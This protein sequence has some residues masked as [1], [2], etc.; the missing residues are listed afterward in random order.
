MNHL[1]AQ[2]VPYLALVVALVAAVIDTKTGRIPNYL[3]L[4]CLLIAPTVHGL[5]GGGLQ[6]ATSLFGAL[7]CLLVPWV[8]YRMSQGTAIGGGDVKLFAALGAWFGPTLGLE[9]EFA[10][11][12]LLGVIAVTKLTFSG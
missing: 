7:L 1:L 10:S 12:V 6:L 2:S 4:P 5:T 9:V 3:T 11:F 8:F